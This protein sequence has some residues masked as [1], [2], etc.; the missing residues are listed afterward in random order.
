M[1]VRRSAPCVLADD[2]IASY[3]LTDGIPNDELVPGVAAM[4]SLASDGE[5]WFPS[6]GEVAIV[7]TRR[8][9]PANGAVPA[10]VVQRFLVDDTARN[11]LARS[12]LRFRLVTLG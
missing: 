3:G 7:D 5:I 2:A 9:V 11:R 4:A 12:R 8:I 10:V 1:A 6:R